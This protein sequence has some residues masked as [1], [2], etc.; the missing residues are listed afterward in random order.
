M[1]AHAFTPKQGP[2]LVEAEVAGPAGG[3]NVKLVLDAG[4]TTSL[5]RLATLLYLGFDPDQSPQRVRMTLGSTVEVVPPAVRT[6]PSVLGQG[7]Y[8]FPVLAHALPKSSAV[9]GLLGLDFLRD[10]VLTIDSRAGEIALS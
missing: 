5:I 7:R 9:D 4:A 10:Q 3:A 1:S 8:G 6:R 2:I